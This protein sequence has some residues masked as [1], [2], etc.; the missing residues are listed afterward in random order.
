MIPVHIS[1]YEICTGIIHFLYEVCTST[2]FTIYEYVPVHHSL[3]MIC[4]GYDSPVHIWLY[5]IVNDNWYISLYRNMI[6]VSF[7]SYMKYVPVHIHYIWNMYQYIIH[8][9]WNMYRLS[10]TSYMKYVLV[11]ISYR[12]WIITGTY[13]IY[14]VNVTSMYIIHSLY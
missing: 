3:Y 2:Y 7:T 13:V 11:H 14:E 5:R 1:L 6:P 10:F 9:I 8:Y 12:E 4:T